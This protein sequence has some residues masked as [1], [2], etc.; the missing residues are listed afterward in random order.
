MRE[1]CGLPIFFGE[2]GIPHPSF[3]HLF[4]RAEKGLCSRP[5]CQE[6][7]DFQTRISRING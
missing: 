5:R 7:Q 1:R 6:R 4:R 3:R 2:Q